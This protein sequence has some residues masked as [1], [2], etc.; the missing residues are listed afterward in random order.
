MPNPSWTL[1]DI[2]GVE[3]AFQDPYFVYGASGL[4]IAPAVHHSTRNAY[5]D[6]ESFQDSTFDAQTIQL[7]I[8]VVGDTPEEMPALRDALYAMLAPVAHGCTL[9]RVRE[10]ATE[11]E[12]LARLVGALDVPRERQQS[13][14]HQRV[15]LTLRAA[16]PHWYDPVAT[17]WVYNV[18]GGVGSFAFPLGFPAGFGASVI[19]V[20][21]TKLYPGH[22]DVYPE[23]RVTGP[24]EQVIVENLTL[25]FTLDLATLGYTIAA[26]EVVTFALGGSAKTVTSSVAGNILQYLSDDSDLGEW[27]VAAHPRAPGGRNQVRVQMENVTNATEAVIQ[28]NTLYAGV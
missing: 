13:G 9:T 8:D 2:T 3:I 6:G 11:R 26:G 17:L 16:Q 23:I 10:D 27:C 7:G 20:T 5:Q 22:V 12:I 19:D 21:E 4:G 1:R 14:A 18:A 28:F 24:A 25:G 15:V